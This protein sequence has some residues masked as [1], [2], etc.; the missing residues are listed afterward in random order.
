MSIAVVSAL[1]ISVIVGDH[2]LGAKILAAVVALAVIV[3]SIQQIVRLV[4]KVGKPL[5]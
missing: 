2:F 1:A 4:K 5:D 3:R